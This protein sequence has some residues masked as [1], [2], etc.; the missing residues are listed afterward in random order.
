M[1]K[2]VEGVT[3]GKLAPCPSSPNC[4]STQSTDDAKKMSPLPFKGTMKETKDKIIDIVKGYSGTTIVEE[5]EDYLHTTFKTKLLKFTD[6]VEFYFDEDEQVVHFRS[7]SRMGY[8]DLGKNKS[9]M[10]E[11]SNSY[12]E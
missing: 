7:A 2:H 6:D 4:V 12:N 11:I 3:D 1:K 5:R 8:S 9:R 10:N